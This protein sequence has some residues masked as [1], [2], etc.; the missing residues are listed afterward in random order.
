[1]AKVKLFDL[2]NEINS[3]KTNVIALDPTLRSVYNAFMINRALSQNPDTVLAAQVMN[4]YHELDKDIQM[5]YLI[6]SIPKKKRYSKWAKEAGSEY[7][8][9]VIKWYSV[10]KNK[11]LEIIGLLDADELADIHR[12]VTDLGGVSKK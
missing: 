4:F 9:S 8:D 12:K 11:A 6:Q 10:S 1:M 7:L 3:G 5:E 2:V